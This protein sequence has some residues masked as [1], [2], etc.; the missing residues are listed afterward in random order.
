M[1][2]KKNPPKNTIVAITEKVNW[3][4]A[5]CHLE[6]GRLDKARPLYEALAQRARDETIA[7][8]A[9]YGL[10]RC[11][12][13]EKNFGRAIAEFMGLATD[14]PVER[15]VVGRAMVQAGRCYEALGKRNEALIV[16][17]S[18]VRKK[19]PGKTEAEARMKQLRKPSFF[20]FR[21]E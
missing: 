12:Q 1:K 3:R 2:L 8:W 14:Y 16:Y 6:L 21:K 13:A 11:H 10:G 5:D 9:H 19:L 4:S 20:F 18:L 17:S 7:A 15:D